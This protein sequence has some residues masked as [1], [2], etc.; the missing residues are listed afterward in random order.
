VPPLLCEAGLLARLICI[1]SCAG[2]V[3]FV[4]RLRSPDPLVS[5]LQL[6]LWPPFKLF[7]TD[8]NPLVFMLHVDASGTNDAL[9]HA[10]TWPQQKARPMQHSGSSSRA[11][12]PTQ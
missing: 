1:P 2:K 12:T 3:A 4:L 5:P 11:A 6:M 7:W 10:G 8:L 9:L